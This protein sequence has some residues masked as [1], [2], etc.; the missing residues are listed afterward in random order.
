MGVLSWVAQAAPP[1]SVSELHYQDPE[2]GDLDFLE[3]I[4]TGSTTYALTGATFSSGIS[5]TFTANSVVAAGER[6]VLVRDRAKFIGRYGTAGIRLAEGNFTGGFSSNGE[7]VALVNSQGATI[8]EFTYGVN[9]Q[10]PSRPSGLGSTLEC[11]NPLGNLNDPTNWRASAEWLGS[12]GR[13]GAG[14]QRVVVINEVLAHSDPPLEDAIELFNL[15]DQPVEIGG[16]YLSNSRA[17]PR[18][19]KIPT[20]TII[21]AKGYQ[22]FYELAGTGSPSGFNPLGQG[23][24]PNFTFS[25]A[26]GDEAVLM[27][28]DASGNFKLWMDTVSFEATA[29]GQSLGRFP[30]GTGKLTTLSALTFGTSVTADFPAEFL[31]VFRTGTGASNAAPR[32]GPL[33]FRRIQYHPADGN[34][35]FLEVQNNASTAVPL[36]DPEHPENTWRLRDGVDFDFPPG[37]TLESGARLLVVPLAPAVFRTK[38]GIPARLPIY[39]PWTNALNNAGERVALYRPD[40]PQGPQHPDAGFVPYVVA[41]AV[42]YSPLAPWPTAADGTGPAL[43]RRDVLQFGDDPAAWGVETTSPPE[44]PLLGIIPITTGV[45]LNFESELGRTYRLERQL[46]W[47]GDWTDLGLVPASGDRVEVD[48]GPTPGFFRI[49][50]E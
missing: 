4:N 47:G 26:Q 50:V 33:V 8:L 18:K 45:R 46:A 23:D 43:L 32:V 42:E 37:V 31:G 24:S 3:L 25:S 17:N 10:W 14:P 34:D 15:T 6:L 38:Y 27:S 19:F 22:V 21:A 9:G 1:L 11:V 5:Y 12:P 7:L 36:F 29:N 48:L 28:A 30:N 44:P 49:R 20:G 35:E 16:W 13:A 2:D 40:P 39:G 41:E